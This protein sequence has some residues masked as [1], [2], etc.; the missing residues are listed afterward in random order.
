MKKRMADFSGLFIEFRFPERIEN[1]RVRFKE[2]AQAQDTSIIHNPG[3]AYEMRFSSKEDAAR[4][5][6]EAAKIASQLHASDELKHKYENMLERIKE[7][8]NCHNLPD[9]PE[10]VMDYVSFQPGDEPPQPGEATAAA[11]AL[12]AAGQFC[13]A[14][15]DDDHEKAVMVF[16]ELEMSVFSM[17][18]Y[19]NAPNVK[20]P[21]TAMMGKLIDKHIQDTRKRIVAANR[22]NKPY[23]NAEKFCIET[24]KSLWQ[25]DGD[26]EIQKQ[27]MLRLLLGELKTKG[28]ATPNKRTLWGWLTAANIVPEYAS[29]GGRRSR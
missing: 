7:S 23:K 4:L 21:V 18:F 9:D 26:R 12:I 29:R 20:G 2:I 28:L 5:K 8:L 11:F 17:T 22:T 14:Y 6:P 16:S 1:L 25:N 19:K 3:G 15:V 10:S 24:A 27:D 13:K